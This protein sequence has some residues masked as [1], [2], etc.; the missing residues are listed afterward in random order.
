MRHLAFAVL[1]IAGIAAA[2]NEDL[3]WQND[4]FSISL[5]AG[6]HA[7]DQQQALSGQAS[8]LGLV[9]FSAQEVTEAGKLTAD[10]ETLANLDRGDIPSFFVDRLPAEKGMACSKLSRT[11]TYNLGVRINQDK[12]VSAVKKYLA[13]SVGAKHTNIDLG[14]CK[15]ARYRV[16]AGKK[17]TPEHWIIDVRAVADGNVVYLFSL[18]NQAANYSRNIDAFERAMATVQIKQR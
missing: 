13:S 9:L 7:Y 4:Q 6:W 5:P 17:G 11:A 1:F 3:L 14:G 2:N 18:R 16:E 12:S 10:V 8:T 15:G